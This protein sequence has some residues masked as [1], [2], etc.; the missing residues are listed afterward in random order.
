MNHLMSVNTS[1]KKAKKNDCMAPP[2]PMARQINALVALSL[3]PSLTAAKNPRPPPTMQMIPMTL[4]NED[5]PE[6]LLIGG[7]DDAAETE[8]SATAEDRD[9]GRALTVGF[10]GTLICG[11][12]IGDRC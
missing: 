7:S 1:I 2:I 12:V 8:A 9:K 3:R 11:V 5:H 10:A 4:R 6:R